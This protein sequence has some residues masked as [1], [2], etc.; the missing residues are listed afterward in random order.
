MFERNVDLPTIGLIAGT[1]LALGTGIGLL[2]GDRLTNEK[3]HACGWSLLAIGAL[4]TI[5][6]VL[7][8]LRSSSVATR[9]NPTH[10]RHTRNG[11]KSRE[12][13]PAT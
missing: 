11:R 9:A 7:R 6:L 4:T 5:P 1:R 13:S 12:I 10:R 8:L 2:L 3:R